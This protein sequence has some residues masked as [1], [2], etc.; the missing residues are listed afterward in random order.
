MGKHEM[1]ESESVKVM[2][3]AL[4]RKNAKSAEGAS[5]ADGGTKQSRAHGPAGGRR[6]FRRK[7][8]G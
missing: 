1:P 3:E 4:A 6:D 7:S 8:G 2:R 5:H